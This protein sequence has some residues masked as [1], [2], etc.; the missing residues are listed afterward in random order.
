MKKL[1]CLLKDR[2]G[3]TLVELVVAMGL[4]S[5]LLLLV[6][7]ALHPA[8]AVTQR[9]HTLESA[10]LL[11]DQV[12]E[13]IRMEVE[14]SCGY[15]KLYEDGAD[16]VEQEGS[17]EWGN[18]VE[19][20]DVD[21]NV[22]LLSA[23]GCDEDWL[24]EMQEDGAQIP[25]GRLFFLTWTEEG[26]KACREPYGEAYYDGMYLKVEFSPEGEVQAGQRAEMLV[27]TA[28]LY[29]DAERTEL[30]RTQSR[31]IALRNEPRWTTEVTMAK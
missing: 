24:T 1:K 21:G 6:S 7:G 4:F 20:L 15:V 3:T 12:L 5:I 16:P 13:E 14:R 29:R 30:V 22:V 10:Q 23:E 19:Y 26:T 8:A 31:T 11:L 18:A 17:L 27:V 25:P 28:S 9:M 2:R